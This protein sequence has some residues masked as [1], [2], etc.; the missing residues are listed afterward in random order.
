MFSEKV[1]SE[2]IEAKLIDVIEKAVAKEIEQLKDD[3]FI[4]DVVDDE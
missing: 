4:E 1:F 3:W 2:K